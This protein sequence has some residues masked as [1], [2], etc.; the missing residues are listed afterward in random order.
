MSKI[1]V[2]DFGGVQHTALFAHRNFGNTPVTYIL[3]R[4]MIGYL[5]KIGIEKDT[6]IIIAQDF[7]SWRKNL[8][9]NYKA[10]RKEVRETF[11]EEQWWKDKYEEINEF[12]KQLNECLPWHWIKIYRDEADDIASVAVRYY[13]DKEVVLVSSD[14]DW[15]M[16]LN[17]ENVKIFSPLQNKK[18]KVAKYKDVPFPVKVLLEKIQ[19]DVSDNLL[20]KPSSE[21]EFEIRKKIVN[22]L[23]LPD[24]IEQPIKE[25][26]QNLLPKNLYLHKVPYR[27]V[28][29]EIRKLYQEE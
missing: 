22:L 20:V 3:M 10:Q 25:Q 1:I 23:E 9:P 5:K 24:E 12:I 17:F 21:R 29:E 28:R 6:L 26:F 18:T 19:G 13:K 11:E 14:K 2:I 4:M 27:S 8:D 16:L 15:E 7:G